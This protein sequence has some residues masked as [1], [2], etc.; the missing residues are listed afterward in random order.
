MLIED[1]DRKVLPRWRDSRVS[2]ALG[3]MDSLEVREEKPDFSEA[4]FS[5]KIREWKAHRSVSFA[6]DVVATALGV[7]IEDDPDATEAA[8]F[9]ADHPDAPAM[10]K[11]VANRF[12]KN[13]AISADLLETTKSELPTD[14]S[15]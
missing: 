7:G 10:A 3:E 14:P 13:E 2:A 4:A 1:K 15:E 11:S 9:V 12:L 5:H 8:S 6:S